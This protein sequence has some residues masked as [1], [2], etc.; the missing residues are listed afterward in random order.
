MEKTIL[1]YLEHPHEYEYSATLLG[2]PYQQ[3]GVWWVEL[4]QTPFYPKGG[5]QP[6]DQGYLI[7][8]DA[9]LKITQVI[10]TE[11][12]RVLHGG[13]YES[14][15]R[16]EL[17]APVQAL[18]DKEP[19]TLHSR[20]HSAGELMLP[21]LAQLGWTDLKPA[22]AIHY[23]ENASVSFDGVIPES[24]RES[25]RKDLEQV[26][27]QMIQE[28]GAVQI[29]RTDDLEQVN[30]IC[31][32]I[33]DYV[34][35]GELVRTVRVRPDYYGRPCRG[36]HVTNLKEIGQVSI[37]KLKVKKGITKISYQVQ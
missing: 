25:L 1:R 20:I 8:C 3:N 4:D 36:T 33:P 7:Q 30:D 12:G 23:V 29:N 2:D 6:A 31:G 18:V 32:F 14:E 35:A 22:G 9:K 19:R 16:L 17:D 13:V 26:M 28:D 24:E 5:G 21:V 10:K 37:T 27:N 11:D 15:A 34:P